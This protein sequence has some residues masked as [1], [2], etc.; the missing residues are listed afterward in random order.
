M[1]VE[2]LTLN[3]M[4]RFQSLQ[5][6]L[7]DVLKQLFSQDFSI[8][9]EL[10]EGKV[11]AD[12]FADETFPA[13]CAT[14][15]SEG[16]YKAQHLFVVP[17]Q[18]IVQAYAWMV[19]GEP[20]GEVGEEQLEGL[21]EGA[22]QIIGQIRAALDG[23]GIPLEVGDIQFAPVDDGESSGIDLSEKQG[24][25]SRVTLKAGELDFAIKHYVLIEAA[26]AGDAAASVDPQDLEDLLNEDGLDEQ[27]GEDESPVDIHQVELG[28][29]GM[30]SNGNGKP[31]NIGMLMDVEL[32]VLVEL[33]RKTML[34]RDVLKLGKGS[35][36]E[37]DKAAGEPLGIFV[38]GRRLA[39]GEVVV[40]D[41]HF[42][43][44]ITQLAG[45]AERIRSLG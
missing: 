15:Q 2:E 39:E 9:M 7:S 37:L 4:A 25:V 40:V 34:I 29:F 3:V 38:N 17:P 41:D 8:E 31:R 1:N 22:E 26:V 23:E 30:G 19:G 13:V 12:S 24:T 33:G 20:E 16:S 5:D 45:P 11:P 18:L 27:G 32:D 28:E 10:E 6:T 14:F 21:K 36:V 43:I 42:G 35:V 44:R